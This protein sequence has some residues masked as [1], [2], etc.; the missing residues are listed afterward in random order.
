[1]DFSGNIKNMNVNPD[2]WQNYLPKQ[3]G[4]MKDCN[5]VY[6]ASSFVWS[7]KKQFNHNVRNNKLYYI[8]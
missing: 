6:V 1:M 7:R 3:A 4:T 8:F 2:V 5:T